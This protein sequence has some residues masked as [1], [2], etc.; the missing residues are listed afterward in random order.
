MQRPCQDRAAPSPG[1]CFHMGHPLHFMEGGVALW[2]G[3]ASPAGLLVSVVGRAWRP[4]GVRVAPGPYGTGAPVCLLRPRRP[5]HLCAKSACPKD[6]GFATSK[7]IA[8]ASKLS[9]HGHPKSACPKDKGASRV[10][11]G[12]QAPTTTETRSP[13]GVAKPPQRAT[14][15]STT[16]EGVAQVVTWAGGGGRGRGPGEGRRG[17]ALRWDLG[18]G[19][20]RASQ[21]WRRERARS[22]GSGASVMA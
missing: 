17:R 20:Q 13:A 15:P 22:E 6:K 18:F 9:A 16:V 3:F 2:G 12:R 21:R 10:P 14:P 4:W 7:L 11:H 8:H 19:D 1:P 5:L